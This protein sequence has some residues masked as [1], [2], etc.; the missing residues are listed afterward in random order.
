[1]EQFTFIEKTDEL[2]YLR[3]VKMEPN[4][5]W[6]LSIMFKD[7]FKLQV[8][9]IQGMSVAE[10]E[11]EYKHLIQQYR[12]K[13]ME[14]YAYLHV[15]QLVERCT[16]GL[17]GSDDKINLSLPSGLIDWHIAGF[18]MF[19]RHNQS[20]NPLKYEEILEAIRQHYELDSDGS[21]CP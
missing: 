18:R 20:K 3:L 9:L 4:K 19:L 21:E 15:F 17:L 2:Q 1:M 16:R 12:P 7:G 13:L 11:A 10:A 8:N 14:D 6:V 5:R